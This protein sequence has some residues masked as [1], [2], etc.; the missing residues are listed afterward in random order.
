ME[1]S[2]YDAC[3][4]CSTKPFGIVG[5]QTDDT[6]F[7]ADEQFAIE[8][9][10]QLQKAGFLAKER[11]RLTSTHDLKFNGG[12]IHLEDD[13]SITLT[14]ERQ[15]KNLKLVRSEDTSMTSSRGAI[16]QNLN[17]K[18][19]YIAQ[20]ARGAYVA[21]VCQPEAAYDLSVAAQ[22]IKL[23]EKDVKTLNKRIQWQLENAVRGLRFVRLNKESLQLLVFTDASF[24]NNKDLSSQIKYVLV[25]ADVSGRANILHWS[26][27][28]CKRVTRSVLASELYAM[29]HGFDIGASIKSTVDKAL[30]INLPLV[31][32]TDSKSLYD[33]LVKLG[34]TQEKRL[35]IDIMCLRLAY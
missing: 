20:R 22:A 23:T 27:V 18:E 14:Q 2:T 12:I 29:A 7:I 28:K 11:E 24:I 1:Q 25:M 15:C 30:G 3:L 34:T 19:Q 6:L 33:C 13:E 10:I 5:L 16:R 9:Q 26:S 4:L 32:C 35:M 8:E 17:T 31:L 21:S